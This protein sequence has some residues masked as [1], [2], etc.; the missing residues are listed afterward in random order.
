[1][2]PGQTH[3]TMTTEDFR[4]LLCLVMV[5]L[6]R[7]GGQATL[8]LAVVQQILKDYR[9]GFHREDVRLALALVSYARAD[10]LT[11]QG[12]EMQYLDTLEDGG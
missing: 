6:H 2:T 4:T 11:A 9:L 8:E 3:V 5:L 7:V 10:E 1:M 12:V